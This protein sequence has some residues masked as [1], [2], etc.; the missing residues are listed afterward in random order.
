METISTSMFSGC[1]GA[2]ELFNFYLLDGLTTKEK[3]QR[4]AATMTKSNNFN[5]SFQIVVLEPSQ[6]PAYHDMLLEFGFKEIAEAENWNYMGRLLTMY[7][8]VNP[9]KQTV[10]KERATNSNDWELAFAKAKIKEKK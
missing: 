1:C 4:F 2:A 5:R 3:R 9:R 7:V 10:L 8:W 6:K